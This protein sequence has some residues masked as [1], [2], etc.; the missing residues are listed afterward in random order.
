[1][2]VVTYALLLLIGFLGG[3]GARASVSRW[4]RAAAEQ[5]W[6]ARR[7]RQSQ[8]MTLEIPRNTERLN[9]SDFR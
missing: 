2:E 4:R 5:R 8:F 9:K 1:M 6:R 7:A 3:Y